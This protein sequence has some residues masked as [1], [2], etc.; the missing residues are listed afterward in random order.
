M[1]CRPKSS[2][3]FTLIELLVVIA[4]I[5]VLAAILF[6]VFSQA[7]EKARATACL[8]NQKQIGT[9]IQM[10]LQDYD[11]RMFFRASTANPSISRSGAVVPSASAL[12]PVSWW[13]ALMPYV[14]NSQIFACPS[15][16][17]PTASKD[18]D[19]QPT[20][21][22]SYIATRAAEALAL[23]QV[24]FPAEILVIVDRWDKTAGPNPK[25]ITDSWIE[26]FNG[27]FDYYPTYH[28]MAL[29]GDRHQEG[30]NGSFFDGHA[31]WLKGQTIGAGKNLTG[32][33]L[34][35][36]YPVAD[37]CDK[38]DPGCTNIDIAD[39]LDP[40]HPIADRNICDA[41]SWP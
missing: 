34:I 28:R 13:N 11:E 7:R 2:R 32:C 19:G 30:I 18:I 3:A 16:P 26:P 24:E 37:M 17:G 22:R 9:A 31:R 15:D 10:Y 25:A 23:A 40:N 39:N 12:L 20:I 4:I 36:A 5:A 1:S 8:S 14:K 38:G 29:A 35:N 27:D 6:P 21:K 33:S 41:F